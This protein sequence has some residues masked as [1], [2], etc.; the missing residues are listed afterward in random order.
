MSAKHRQPIENTDTACFACGSDNP[1]GLHMQF[2]TD[3]TKLYSHVMPPAH[4]T[5]WDHLL[6]GGIISTILDEIM[7]WTAIHLLQRVILTKSLQVEF[8]RP[9]QV[10]T[11]LE[12]QGWVEKQQERRAWIKGV[13]YD[14][15]EMEMARSTGE[16]VLFAPQDKVLQRILPLE[17]LAKV[18]QRFQSG[19]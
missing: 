1:Y 13:I 12:V 7:A 8:M 9:I 17:M 4:M 10:N 16:M 18:Q 11:G 14:E 2:S 19:S 3:G 5:G 6:H 15:Q